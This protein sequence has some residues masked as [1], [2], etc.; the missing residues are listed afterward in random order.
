LYRLLIVPDDVLKL[1]LSESFLDRRGVR[2]RSALTAEEALAIALVW[3]PSLVV[4]GS[5]LP[6]MTA[7][8][9]V[10]RLRE[11]TQQPAP[12][13][14]RITSSVGESIPE[15]VDDLYDAHLVA[16]VD[17]H[18]L[19]ETAAAVL[20]LRQRRWP[21][22]KLHVTVS[23]HGL[24]ADPEDA[25]DIP[26]TT[27]DVSEGGLRVEPRD[28]LD[29]GQ[30]G[31][32]TLVLPGSQERLVLGCTVRALVDEVQLHY[33]IEF[34]GLSDVAHQALRAFVERFLPKRGSP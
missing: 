20:E 21:R 24:G 10:K 7:A 15:L 14:I 16:P 23:L 18:Q 29:V 13:L 4:F 28:P 2:T 12:H 25:S 9:F 11:G 26:A 27:L 34:V 22:V 19:L 8:S 30:G 17:A 33:G 1:E 31:T 32:V 3:R 6:D 5:V